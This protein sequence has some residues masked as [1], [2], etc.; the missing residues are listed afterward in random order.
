MDLYM[1]LET[2][3]LYLYG[4]YTDKTII[5]D[6]KQIILDIFKKFKIKFIISKRFNTCLV[7]IVDL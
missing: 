4:I 6:V 3:R 5:K 7:E 2:K 1:Y